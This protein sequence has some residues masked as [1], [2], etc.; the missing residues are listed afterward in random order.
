[1]GNKI[2]NYWKMV[3]FFVQL[4]YNEVQMFLNISHCLILLILCI[5]HIKDLLLLHHS[6]TGKPN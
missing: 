6:G 2:K 3:D 4:L 1:M 5:I